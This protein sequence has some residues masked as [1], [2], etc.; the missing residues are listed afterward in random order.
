VQVVIPAGWALVAADMAAQ[1]GIP[2]W[3]ALIAE[4]QKDSDAERLRALLLDFTTRPH[5]DQKMI[6]CALALGA[7][8]I[9]RA[10]DDIKI[11][12]EPSGVLS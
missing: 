6:A 7:N 12:P 3:Q 11:V 4:L 9:V 10:E 5:L 8:L 2:R 1:F